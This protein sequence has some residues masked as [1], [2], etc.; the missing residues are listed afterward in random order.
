[1]V[2]AH[3]SFRQ[4]DQVSALRARAGVVGTSPLKAR[5]HVLVPGTLDL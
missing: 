1:V 4:Q 5:C 2:R 3:Q